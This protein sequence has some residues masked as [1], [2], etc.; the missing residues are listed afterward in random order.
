MANVDKSVYEVSRTIKTSKTH[1]IS[2]EGAK[3][4]KIPTFDTKDENGDTITCAAYKGQYYVMKT[5]ITP[6]PEPIEDLISGREK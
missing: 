3:H 6:Y 4:Y 2:I 5:T 1:F